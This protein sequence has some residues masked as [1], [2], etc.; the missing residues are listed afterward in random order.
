MTV[1]AGYTVCV[2]S[3]DSFSCT[4]LYFKADFYFHVHQF[5]AV[6]VM[7]ALLP[8]RHC[9]PPDLGWLCV[10]EKLLVAVKRASENQMFLAI[11]LVE[12]TS[13]LGS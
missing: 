5:S 7:G 12:M 3:L 11:H 1:P 4:F 13:L 8:Q 10:G 2:T 9:Q 6:R